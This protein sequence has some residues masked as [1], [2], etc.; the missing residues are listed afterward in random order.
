MKFPRQTPKSSTRRGSVAVVVAIVLLALVGVAALVVDLGYARLVQQQL[1]SAADASAL[2]AVRRL[3][4]TSDGLDNARATAVDVAAL[5]DAHGEPV[6]LDPNEGNSVTGDVCLGVWDDTSGTFSPSEDASE[7]NAVQVLARRND[8]TPL[9]SRVAFGRTDLGAGARA[10]AALRTRLSAGEVPYYIPFALPTCLWDSYSDPEIENSVFTLSPA[11]TDNTGWASVGGQP[12]AAW[13]AEHLSRIGPCMEEYQAT[14]TVSDE[15]AVASTSEDVG[16][17]NGVAASGT[18]ALADAIEGGLAW[19]PAVWGPL[20]EQSECSSVDEAN[21]GNAIMG[22]LPV[23]EDSG[24]YCDPKAAWNQYMPLKG[25][26]WAAV[27]DVCAKGAAKDK[28]VFLKV[29]MS[30]I[31]PVGTWYGGSDFGIE[32]D[33]PAV[34]VR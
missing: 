21:Y 25:F 16:L 8:L 4:Q 19:D 27:Y 1:Q 15:C 30:H 13:V 14:G 29:D 20:P 7:I 28:N 2:G 5:N 33:G 9:L 23:F 18:M 3:D 22:P 17:A 10:V 34:V 11:G 32:A 6:V 12:N 26:V 24:S 31:Y